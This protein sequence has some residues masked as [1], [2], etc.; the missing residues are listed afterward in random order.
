MRRELM[1]AADM[2]SQAASRRY[3]SPVSWPG[4]ARPTVPWPGVA[5]P[6]FLWPNGA[7][8]SC[9]VTCWAVLALLGMGS[10][11]ARATETSA[12][13]FDEASWKGLT[14][15][16]IGPFRG[17]RVTAVTGV[18]GQPTTFY[19]GATGGG[20]WKTEDAGQ[21][22]KNVSDGHVATGSV[23]ALAVAPSD[24]NVI[25]AGMGE[26]QV[27]GV[28]TTHGDGVYRST[29]GGHTWT[30]L[31]L[32][33][34][35]QISRIRVHPEDP[36][37]VYVAAQG[38]PWIASEERGIYRST[39]GGRTWV[40]ILAVDDDG[41]MGGDGP[42]NVGASDLA[43]DA[44][45]AR[46]LYA[47]FWHHQRLPWKVVSGGAGSGLYKSTDHGDTWHKL[48]GG[49]PET[50]GKVGVAVSPT[51]PGRVWA[52]VEAADDDGGLYRSDDGGK[53][54]V[55]V[56]RERLLRA[57]SWYYTKVFADPR[58]ANTV[59]V[60]NAPMLRSIDGG[61]TFERVSTPHGDNHDLWVSS[62]RPHR[63]INGN[64]GG[65]NVSWTEGASWSTQSNQPTGQFYRVITDNRFPYYVYAGQQDNST[66]AVAS[67]GNQGI[68]AAD[69]Y[70]VGGCE[71]AHI[72]FDPEQPVH[73]YAGCYQGLISEWD[74]ATG[75]QR[76]VMAYPIQGL[77]TTP[78]EEKYRFNWNAPIVVSPHDPSVLYHAG[79]VVLR[80]VDR[81]VNWRVISDDL[82]R[83][84]DEK[85]GPGGGPITNEAAGAETYGTVFSLTAS[86][87]RPGELWAGSDD[88]LV[89][90]TRSEGETWDDVTPPDL[91]ESQING[92]EVSPH[93]PDRIILA[94]NRY[95]LGDDRPYVYVTED[96]GVSWEL[97]IEGL[98]DTAFVRAVREDPERPG[99]LY[100]GTESGL[101]VSLDNGQQWHTFQ[102]NMPRVPITDLTLRQGDLVAATQGRG[103]WILDD[104][105]PLRQWLERDD[106]HR[107]EASASVEE[108]TEDSKEGEEALPLRLYRPQTA[109]R[110]PPL[111][112]EAPHTGKNPPQG[113]VL[114]FHLEQDVVDALETTSEEDTASELVLEIVD[115]EGETVRRFSSFEAPQDPIEPSPTPQAFRLRQTR[116]LC[117]P[118]PGSTVSSGTCE[119]K[120]CGASKTSSCS[121]PRPIVWCQALISSGSPGAR[122]VKRF[123]WRFSRILGKPK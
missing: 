79:N 115:V 53:R 72:A 26:A 109:F 20:I 85:Q 68:D 54:F 16:N 122:R 35:R 76:N 92:I 52:L 113:A 3:R 78:R 60:L 106:M 95:K 27:R 28:T 83:D 103:L 108:A 50:L 69:W 70:A 110:L 112:S 88:G 100:A 65:A 31:G 32:E 25:Y 102:L 87:H 45:N 86:P 101:F 17:G 123:R 24:P 33:E 56:N 94:V 6:T 67:R 11:E 1:S 96:G 13:V 38:N 59:Y 9:L 2:D 36:D 99:L 62:D 43:M 39:D 75:Q 119:A 121:A 37:W 64:D 61:R 44:G 90:V 77:G 71:S 19:F 116:R 46:I 82:S 51:R 23:G 34:T 48:E 89:H 73:V 117:P 84:E 4:V 55:Q 63:M 22:W 111:G 66:V 57:R 5:R 21:T 12:S 74:M 98:P 14:W 58:D 30:H 47:A 18:V 107:P 29:D 10:V 81:G 7:R 41:E 114:Y 40:Q 118:K 49:L 8:L 93:Q 15:R 104:L 97:R 105:S 91:Q 42:S 120:R 80:S